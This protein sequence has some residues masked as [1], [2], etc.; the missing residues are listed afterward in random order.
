MRTIL[1]NGSKRPVALASAREESPD[2]IGREVQLLKLEGCRH[3]GING[4]CHREADR[5]AR[6]G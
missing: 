4:K 6:A 1:G 2:S 3:T 5:P